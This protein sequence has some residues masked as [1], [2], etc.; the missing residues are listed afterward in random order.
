M[1][2]FFVTTAGNYELAVESSNSAAAITSVLYPNDHTCVA[3]D[4][5]QEILADRHLLE[6]VSLQVSNISSPWLRRIISQVGK[7]LRL[8]QQ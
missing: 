8:K 5:L 3:L 1:V 4:F 7:E 2:D 6:H